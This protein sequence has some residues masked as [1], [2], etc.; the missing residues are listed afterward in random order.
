MM[1]HSVYSN[2]P[3]CTV[4]KNEARAISSICHSSTKISS[5]EADVAESLFAEFQSGVPEFTK[6]NCKMCVCLGREAS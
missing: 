6:K 2:F 3:G 1:A 4:A 5:L